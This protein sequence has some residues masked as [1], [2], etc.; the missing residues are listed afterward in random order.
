MIKL[1]QNITSVYLC[2]PTYYTLK[3]AKSCLHPA[4][5][6]HYQVSQAS[7][8]HSDT[9]DTTVCEIK[10]LS[11]YAGQRYAINKGERRSFG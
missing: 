6:Y 2:T 4:L 1:I 5:V 3:S 8:S 9:S 11:G 10:C 7:I